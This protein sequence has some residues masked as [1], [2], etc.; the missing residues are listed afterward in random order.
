MSN[1][2]P[3]DLT[4]V[5]SHLP[6]CSLSILWW[7]NLGAL[8]LIFFSLLQFIFLYFVCCLSG[9]SDP[10]VQDMTSTYEC[11]YYWNCL[12]TASLGC[13]L[14]TDPTSS[15]KTRHFALSWST[16]SNACHC[17]IFMLLPIF[18]PNTMCFH[19]PFV[20]V[21]LPFLQGLVPYPRLVSFSRSSFLSLLRVQPYATEPA[22]LFP[23]TRRQGPAKS[24]YPFYSKIIHEGNGGQLRNTCLY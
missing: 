11:P 2:T 18:W 23:L 20:P 4:S 17:F 24:L 12:S 21:F 10:S 14:V 19:L 7:W 16:V 8:W 22:A 1:T 13:Y 6:C 15:P 3:H 9:F 5:S